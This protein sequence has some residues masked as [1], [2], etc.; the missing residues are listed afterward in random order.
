MLHHFFPSAVLLAMVVS[1]PAYSQR[2][3]VTPLKRELITQPVND[4]KLV[5]LH[6]NTRASASS[7][8]DRGR[9][10]DSL[11]MDH[12]LIS[13]SVLLNWSRRSNSIHRIFRIRLHPITISG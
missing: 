5:T 2:A 7:A 11:A 8:N 13:Y 1:P 9:V 3:D 12:M 10:S 4:Q 6:G